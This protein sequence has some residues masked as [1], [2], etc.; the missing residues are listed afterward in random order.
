MNVTHSFNQFKKLLFTLQLT[1]TIKFN[2]FNVVLI[3]NY[4]K[5]KTKTSS[6]FQ[7]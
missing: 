3:S 2:N 5:N 6:R 1:K 7:I 4:N